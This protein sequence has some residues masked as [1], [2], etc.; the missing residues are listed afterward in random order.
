M[1]R[2]V[3]LK[4]KGNNK[5]DY[6]FDKPF[7]KKHTIIAKEAVQSYVA[8]ILLSPAK[9]KNI[10]DYVPG[11][12][13][14]DSTFNEKT[15]NDPRYYLFPYGVMY[16]GNNTLNH[17][18]DNRQKASNLLFLSV[19]FRL[20]YTIFIKI[21]LIS[22]DNTNLIEIEGLIDLLDKLFI[23]QAVNKKLLSIADEILIDQI[24]DDT[25]IKDMIGDNLPKFLKV[26]IESKKCVKI[27]VD[28]IES[29]VNKPSMQTLKEEVKQIFF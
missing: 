16:Y 20:V 3:K 5:Y 21:G 29:K 8:G 6:L 18:K 26:T 28:K 24:F 10:G 14:Y 12:Q 2:E 4:I 23:C 17:K 13:Y 15:P 7:N 1:L 9:A 25:S 27:I 22:E 19:Y 11:G